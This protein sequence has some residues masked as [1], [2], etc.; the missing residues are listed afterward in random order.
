MDNELLNIFDRE[1]NPIGVATREEVHKRGHWHETFHC[2]FIAHEEGKEYVYL[3]IRSDLK[4]DYPGLLDITAAGHLLAN[5]TELD[6]VREVEE[7][8]GIPI[9]FHELDSLGI[10]D[11]S[12]ENEWLIDKE[13]AHV[14]LYNC[15][16]SFDDFK[17]QVE[18]VSGIVRVEFEQFASMWTDKTDKIEVEGIHLNSN[19]EKGSI[20]KLVTKENFVPHERSYYEEVILGIRRKLTKNQLSK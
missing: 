19:G 12:I 8:L 6:G 7:E 11:Y 3:Q 16:L 17:L 5:E 18:E 9:A 4:K 13:F 20:R 10:I 1:K 15:S 2:W 14:F